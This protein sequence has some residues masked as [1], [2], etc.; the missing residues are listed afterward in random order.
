DRYDRSRRFDC[1]Q[2]ALSHIDHGRRNFSGHRMS[3]RN[4]ILRMHAKPRRREADVA[5]LECA[6]VGEASVPDH[7]GNG[8]RVQREC[9]CRLHATECSARRCRYLSTKSFTS[10]WAMLSRVT[11][12]RPFHAG[13][14]LTSMT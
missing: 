14:P 13:M 3:A 5:W 11:D 12:C 6:N 9:P 1:T 2:D 7:R 4:K 10:I 8:L